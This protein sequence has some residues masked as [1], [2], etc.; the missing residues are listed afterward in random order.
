MPEPAHQLDACILAELFLPA[1]A[2][3][4]YWK[5]Q[6]RGY[7]FR[8]AGRGTIKLVSVPALGEI[9]FALTTKID[10]EEEKANAFK[11][12]LFLLKKL[13][14]EFNSPKAG[15][16]RIALQILEKDSR[17]EPGD[18]LR[19]A[20]AIEANAVFITID[21]KLL[22]NKELARFGARIIRP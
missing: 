9:A 21:E 15:A 14:I 19:V 11:D 18:A 8:H 10:G 13:E 2:K 20:E 17:I 16:Y 3:R 1:S 12:L 22:S 5:Q 4:L 7:L 6:V